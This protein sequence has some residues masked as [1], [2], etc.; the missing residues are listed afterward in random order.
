[1]GA[2]A[3]ENAGLE[4]ALHGYVPES[5]VERARSILWHKLRGKREANVVWI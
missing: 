1:M 2:F 4:C 5:V 3:F